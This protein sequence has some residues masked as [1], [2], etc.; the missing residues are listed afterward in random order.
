MIPR[1]TVPGALGTDGRTDSLFFASKRGAL[2]D[3]D[4]NRI[5]LRLQKGIYPTAL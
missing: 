4:V 1:R 2:D 5:E 3:Q